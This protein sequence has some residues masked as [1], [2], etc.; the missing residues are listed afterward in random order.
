MAVGMGRI[1]G[2]FVTG[3]VQRFIPNNM[4]IDAVGISAPS[5]SPTF[6]AAITIDTSPATGSLYQL[7][8]ANAAT[9]PTIGA[10]STTINGQRLTI[11]IRNSSGGAM[12]A[13]TFNAIYK[14]GAAWTNPANNFS[15]AIDFVCNGTNW[16]EVS[17]T[18]ADVAN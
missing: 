18:A 2:R 8:I 15:R 14:L 1:L 13:T 9:A 12:G 7:V 6:G 3:A 4:L 11:Q 16:V 17:R 5:V 10:P